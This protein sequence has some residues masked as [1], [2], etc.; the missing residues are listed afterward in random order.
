MVR[1]DGHQKDQRDGNSRQDSDD[2][3][4]FWQSPNHDALKGDR[5]KHRVGV[6]GA[7][8]KRTWNA[9]TGNT[10][11]ISGS[12]CFQVN[13]LPILRFSFF[14]F[15][16][17]KT[18]VWIEL[19][20]RQPRAPRWLLLQVWQSFSKRYIWCNK[21]D[22]RRSSVPRK[23]RLHRN[24]LCFWPTIDVNVISTSMFQTIVSRCV[25]MYSTHAEKRISPET[26][27]EYMN[28]SYVS[29]LLQWIVLFLAKKVIFRVTVMRMIPCSLQEG[30][31]K[32]TKQALLVRESALAKWS[33]QDEA[34]R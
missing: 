7:G 6:I 28:A 25:C 26:S 1:R 24:W 14:F 32:E 3:S 20:Q 22:W 34:G 21:Q 30:R 17:P 23:G 33:F 31:E 9:K 13:G 19:L 2:S 8:K 12:Y 15:A 5:E 10:E 4:P 18:I 16:A 11:E 29:L 27:K